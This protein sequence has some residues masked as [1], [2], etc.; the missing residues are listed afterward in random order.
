MFSIIN[1]FF[2]IRINVMFT[3]CIN[4]LTPCILL[5]LMVY[6][7]VHVLLYMQYTINILHWIFSTD[8]NVCQ[9][10]G[11]INQFINVKSLIT[12]HMP[13]KCFFFQIVGKKWES[14]IFMKRSMYVFAIWYYLINLSKQDTC[15]RAS[16]KS[17]KQVECISVA[18]H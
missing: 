16:I 18:F 11:M 14:T 4:V 13:I 9:L 5:G 17:Q 3:T 6:V 15:T 10:S 12:L 2:S 1:T 8:E 7:L